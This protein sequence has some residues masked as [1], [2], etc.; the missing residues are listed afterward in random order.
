MKNETIFIDLDG[1][2]VDC[3]GGYLKTVGKSIS[4]ELPKL[5]SDSWNSPADFWSTVEP[6]GPEWWENLEPLP[7]AQ[8]LYDTTSRLTHV[9]FLSSPGHIIHH[10][11]AS[12]YAAQGKI[13]WCNKHFPDVPLLLGYNKHFC[14]N[15]HNYLIDDNVKQTTMFREYGGNVWLFPNQFGWWSREHGCYKY[16]ESAFSRLIYDS[17]KLGY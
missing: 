7:W 6:Y 15:F 4:E 9:C 11:R 5:L 10:P 1:V 13:M 3:I 14:S 16:S 12:A 8:L 17:V 2:M